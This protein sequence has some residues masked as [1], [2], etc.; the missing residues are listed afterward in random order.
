MGVPGIGS[1]REKFLVEGVT[2]KNVKN[3][4]GSY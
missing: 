4:D 1:A 3:I 2:A